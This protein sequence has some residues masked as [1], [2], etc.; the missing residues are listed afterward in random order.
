MHPAPSIILFTS[1]S[2]LGFGLL[3]VLCLGF[4]AIAGRGA[5]FWFT[6]GYVLAGG[7]LSLSLLH[8]GQPTRFL[9]AF[10]QWK[11]SWLSREA[12]ISTV[13]LAV[14]GTQ[15]LL[16]IF[17]TGNILL[18]Y[19][20][21]ALCLATVFCTAMIYTQLKTVPRWN[22]FL[23]PVQ[24]LLFAIA[25][26]TLLTGRKPCRHAG[27]GGPCVRPDGGVACRGSTDFEVRLNHRICNRTWRSGGSVRSFAGTATHRRELPDQGNGFRHRAPPLAGH[28]VHL[29]SLYRNPAAVSPRHAD[30]RCLGP[31]TDRRSPHQRCRLVALA[32]FRR[33]RACRRALLRKT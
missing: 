9:K 29:D 32:L 14:T 31:A 22:H 27:S 28:Q 10:T 1:I 33:G 30:R 4:P 11:T 7:G 8:L 15:A 13:T 12:V 5:F 18:G 3:G 21:A 23:T 6:A 19:A 24:F 20:A 2:G 25:G 26:G 17:A 16:I